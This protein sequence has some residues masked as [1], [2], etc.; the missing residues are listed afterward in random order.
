MLEITENLLT[1]IAAEGER[2]YPNE[3]CG[4]IIG[5]LI[6]AEHKMAEKIIPCENRFD[7]EE[8]F[9]RFLIEPKQMLKVQREA[10]KSGKD[11]TGFYH[12]HP[13]CR[14]IPSEYDRSHALP[15]YSYIIV[16]VTGG[17]QAE[18]LSWQLNNDGQ[19]QS[20]EIH[21]K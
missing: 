21:I 17:K 13:D 6:S 20:E 10:A 2:G 3:C 4:F 16:S 8:Q 9:H 5:E 11:I 15:I 12:S 18:I 7:D 1:A 14:A 19:F